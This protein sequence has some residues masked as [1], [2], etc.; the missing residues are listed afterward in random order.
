MENFWV[1][2]SCKFLFILLKKPLNFVSPK[3]ANYINCMTKLQ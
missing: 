3:L 2:K 1:L